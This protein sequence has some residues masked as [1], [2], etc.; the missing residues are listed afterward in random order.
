M[1]NNKYLSLWL[2]FFYLLPTLSGIFGENT[3]AQ[4]G[5]VDRENS[6]DLFLESGL[7][8]ENI[9]K[10]FGKGPRIREL[11]SNIYSISELTFRQSRIYVGAKRGLFVTDDDGQT[12][13]KMAIDKESKAVFAVVVNPADDNILFAGNREGLWKSEDGGKVWSRVN[14]GLPAGCVPLSIAFSAYSPNDAYMGSSHHGVFRSFDGGN[15]WVP[16]GA[17]LPEAI[18]GNR[19]TPVK[20]LLVDPNN[21]DVAY[22]ATELSGIYKT[23]DGGKTWQAINVG[24]PQL[25]MRRTYPPRLAVSLDDPSIIY[26][27]I[28]RSVHSHLVRTYMYRS[29]NMGKSWQIVETEFPPNITVLSLRVD[30]TDSSI[31]YVRSMQGDFRVSTKA[32]LTN[33]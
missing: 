10:R 13:T 17:G 29:A 26:A 11:G 14:I 7:K 4:I 12:W 20:S 27:T 16:A 1:K 6:S 25:F 8:T 3:F 22:V 31:V 21:G 23:T 19:I 28:G 15:S 33:K 5:K 24:L 30:P 9:A 18:G 32:S 2:M